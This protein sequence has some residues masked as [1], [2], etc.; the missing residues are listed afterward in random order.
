MIDPMR[1]DV[2]LHRAILLAVA[3]ALLFLR[4][5]PLG[6]TA[7]DL[8]GPDLLLCLIFA[9]VTRRPDYLP[10]LMIA[11]VV[12]FEDLLLQRPPG[13]WAALVVLG[14]E[15]LRSRIALTR[16]LSFL[17]EWLFIAGVMLGLLMTYR[18]VLELSFMPQTNFGFALTQTGASILCYP[19]VVWVSHATLGVH[20]PGMGEIDDMGRRL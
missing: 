8:P 19:L 18:F 17:A 9:W 11:A 16:E 1:R 10:A 4:L 2:W 5:L 3:A 15:L 6:G 7:G 12:L 20:K 14:A 13:L